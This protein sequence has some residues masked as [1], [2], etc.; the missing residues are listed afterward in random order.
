[1]R[2]TAALGGA[3][4]LLADGFYLWAISQQGASDG[5]LRVP[6]VAAYLAACGLAAFAGAAL[7][8]PS[9]RLALL[10]F[11]AAGTLLFGVLGIFSIGLTSWSCRYPWSSPCSE[12][13]CG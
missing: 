7:P 1:M 11:S 8:W 3:L 9:A 6:F 10:S 13:A 5:T 2:R 4:I 12:L